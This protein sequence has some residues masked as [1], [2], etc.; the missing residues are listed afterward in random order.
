MANMKL[1]TDKAIYKPSDNVELTTILDKNNGK[2]IVR[3]YDREK[4]ITENTYLCKNRSFMPILIKLPNKDNKQYLIKVQ[5]ATTK[6]VDYIAVNV[7]SNPDAFAVMGFVSKYSVFNSKENEKLINK[8]ARLHINTLQYYDY[9]EDHGTPVRLDKNGKVAEQWKDLF[10]RVNRRDV[11]ADLIKQAKNKNML[12]M[13]Y[14][15]LNG[16]SY[17]LKSKNFENDI[18]YEKDGFTS[19]MMLFENDKERTVAINGLDSADEKTKQKH[20]RYDIALTDY[21]NLEY[22]KLLKTKLHDVLKAFDFDGFHIDSLGES[23]GKLKKNNAPF[24]SEEQKKGFKTF[25]DNMKY[26]FYNKRLG[27]NAVGAF[28]QEEVAPSAVSYLYSELWPKAEAGEVNAYNTYNDIFNSIKKQTLLAD[29]NKSIIIPAYMNKGNSWNENKYFN[30]AS[31]V[32][33]NLV[34]M[35]AGAT[36]LEM[37]EHMLCAPYFAD[38]KGL[39]KPDLEDYIVKQ[40]DFMVAYHNLLRGGEF[41]EGN[42]WIYGRDYSCNQI[43]TNRISTIEKTSGSTVS[44]SLINTVNLNSDDWRDDAKKREFAKPIEDVRVGFSDKVKLAENFAWY[45][46]VENPE[47]TRVALD[48]NRSFSLPQLDKHVT[49]WVNIKP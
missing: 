9:M 4:K 28:G 16:T 7:A 1:S 48:K 2:L 11:I 45:A 37:G 32:L 27:F 15:L 33:M 8:L 24:T 30:N 26:E 29:K 14:H 21:T 20:A 6:D 39:I 12:N 3:V 17:A 41:T 43:K 19:D 31:V 35:C 38:D 5:N 34:I 44:L 46:S 49:I 36:H 18:P 25:L 10:K 42:T 23:H 47:P 13:A 40:Y 22:Q